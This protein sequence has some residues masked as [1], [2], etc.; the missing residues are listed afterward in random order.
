MDV[1]KELAGVRRRVRAQIDR[2]ARAALIRAGIDVD[3]EE[4]AA[5]AAAAAE[6]QRIATDTAERLGRNLRAISD[7]WRTMVEG[8]ARGFNGGAR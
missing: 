7:A 3:A 5:S 4:A 8:I 1:E 2:D 6:R